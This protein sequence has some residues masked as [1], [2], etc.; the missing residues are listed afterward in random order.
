M[1]RS[2]SHALPGESFDS[3]A[4]D[5]DDDDEE[6]EDTRAAG[7][8]AVADVAPGRLRSPSDSYVPLRASKRAY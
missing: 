2:S 5:D 6:E 3:L 7:F 8:T 1:G 4:E